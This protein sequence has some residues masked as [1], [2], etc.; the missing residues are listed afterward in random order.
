[1]L[2]I[3]I[4]IN[5]IAK[6][7]P[8]QATVGNILELVK[9]LKERSPKTK[10]LVHSILPTNA[11]NRQNKEEVISHYNKNDKVVELNKMLER[12]TKENDFT[13]IDLYSSFK[14]TN[15]NLN[16]EFAEKDGLHLN[17]HGYILWS[18]ILKMN[19]L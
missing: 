11:S 1:M 9:K 16:I 6:D 4:G 8:V 19:V 17:L 12:N 13:F 3:S 14:D 10:I 7:I 2:F 5:D 18:D 15:G